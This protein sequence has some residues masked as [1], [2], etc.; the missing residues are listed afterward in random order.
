MLSMDT[1]KPWLRR[2]GLPLGA[3][4][5]AGALTAGCES[6]DEQ[7]RRWIFQPNKESWWGGV[8]A[9]EGM[10]DVWIGF[11]SRESGVPVRLH[12]LWHP[13]D[14]PDAPVLLYL[15]GARWNVTGSAP[16]VRRMQQLGFS[17]LAVDYRGFGKSTDALPSETLAY[18]DAQAAWEWL[19]REHPQ[20]RRYIFG[21]SLG[22]A[23]AV[24]LASG[25]GDA[26]G[27]I[28]EGS[29]PSIA[30]VVGTFKW[31]WLP[32]SAL[33]TQRFDA[34]RSIEQVKVPV[35]VV[36]GSA[37]RL[38]SPKLGQELYERVPGRKRWIEVEGGS[39]HSTNAL[40]Q[41][42][43]REALADLFGLGGVTTS[44]GD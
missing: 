44:A 3:A 20:S 27:L 38:I 25:V 1:T 36:H 7:Q 33:I 12:A 40:A 37:D 34:G 11:T 17:V 32:M 39:H 18:E 43:Y 42:M 5:F 4:L 41:A 21:H 30:A 6:L 31:G 2:L 13:A 19:A 14:D 16:R 15:H 23:I 8:Q 26:Q 29:F 9:A 22:A 28:L 35:L 10:Q 24:H